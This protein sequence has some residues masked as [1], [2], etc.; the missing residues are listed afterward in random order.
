M[1]ALSSALTQTSPAILPADLPPPPA[2]S[3]ASLSLSQISVQER[4]A[5]RLAKTPTPISWEQAARPVSSSAPALAAEKRKRSWLPWLIAGG[6]TLLLGLFGFILVA[7]F[8]LFRNQT[9]ENNLTPTLPAAQSTNGGPTSRPAI[10]LSPAVEITAPA[11]ENPVTSPVAEQAPATTP[12]LLPTVPPAETTLPVDVTTGTAPDPTA[13]VLY[14][15]GRLV[16]LLYDDYSFYILNLD[17]ERIGIRD[18]TFE[19][20]NTGGQPAGY[21]FSGSLWSQFYFYL[22]SGQCNRIETTPAPA[23][24]R[25]TQCHGYNATV[26]PQITNELVFWINR[27]GVAEFRILWAGEEVGRCP[28]GA[29]QCEVYLPR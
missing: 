22:N 10:V 3:E 11:E 9:A 16:Q 21:H 6:G 26:T 8:L 24:L 14:P 5:N 28:V 25:P 13:T 12:A 4:V 18:I 20:L 7:Y 23:Y 15:D 2:G 1:Q 29:G 19:A 27:S 17:S